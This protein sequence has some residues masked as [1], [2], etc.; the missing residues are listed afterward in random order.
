MAAYA[1][2]RGVQRQRRF[3]LGLFL[4]VNALTC[5]TTFKPWASLQNASSLLLLPAFA[6]VSW[7][8]ARLVLTHTH[9][10]RQIAFQL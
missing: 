5:L 6:A 1:E 9:L 7:A 10:Q 4:F 3:F 2:L 8:V